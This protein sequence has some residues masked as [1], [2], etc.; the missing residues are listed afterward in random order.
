MIKTYPRIVTNAVANGL[1][2]KKLDTLCKSIKSHPKNEE[3]QN[4][5]A[6]YFTKS[7]QAYP[8]YSGDPVRVNAMARMNKF[9]EQLNS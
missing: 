6:D 7:L 4:K 2:P 3:M 9:F 5:I 1:P 8:G